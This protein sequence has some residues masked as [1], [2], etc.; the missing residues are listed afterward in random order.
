MF[1]M[2]FPKDYLD[3][4]KTPMDLG[5]MKARLNS[6]FYQFAS[7]CLEDLFKM[8]TNCYIYNRPG[9][10]IVVM[11]QHLES[12]ARQHLQQMLS[13]PKVEIPVLQPVIMRVGQTNLS[14]E[15]DASKSAVDSAQELDGAALFCQSTP[16]VPAVST[17]HDGPSRSTMM[18]NPT[19]RKHE[20]T[21][22]DGTQAASSSRDY[23]RGL[24]R[25]K[26]EN[27]DVNLSDSLTQ[28]WNLLTYISS[29][30]LRVS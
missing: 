16:I 13:C 28:C 29:A 14:T 7:E 26:E 22:I 12:V 5:T 15:T 4:I 11:A 8:F 9:D 20:S 10:D 21:S 18:Q 2:T 23:G 25:P 24:R 1:L 19:T 17:H 3:V 27:R 30:N 6:K